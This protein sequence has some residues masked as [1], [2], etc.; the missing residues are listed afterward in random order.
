M[1]W[2]TFIKQIELLQRHT[3]TWNRHP[4]ARS[5]RP[6]SSFIPDV[7]K[8]VWHIIPEDAI[9][10]IRGTRPQLCT[11]WVINSVAEPAAGSA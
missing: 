5:A 7:N 8:L 9:K 3:E 2:K 1:S 4:L 11:P 6:K 10:A